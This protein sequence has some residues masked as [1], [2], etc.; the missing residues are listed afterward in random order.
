MTSHVTV[1]R[2][3]DGW[4]LRGGA[5]RLPSC[6]TGGTGFELLGVEVHCPHGRHI[7]YWQSITPP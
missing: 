4:V 3:E 6:C 2:I 7:S 1:V 5:L